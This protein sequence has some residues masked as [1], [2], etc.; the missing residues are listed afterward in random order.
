M[1]F[2]VFIDEDGVLRVLIH[3]IVCFIYSLLFE[4]SNVCK[5]NDFVPLVVLKLIVVL[6]GCSLLE[7]DL[8]ICGIFMSKIILILGHLIS[9]FVLPNQIYRESRGW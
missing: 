8:I 7:R 5:Y 1:N 2:R 9:V 3:I 6:F 4:D